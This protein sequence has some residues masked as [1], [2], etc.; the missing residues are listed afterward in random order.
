[1]AAAT[2]LAS[3]RLKILAADIGYSIS[4]REAT[5]A[6]SV[7]YLVGTFTPQIVGQLVGR[8]AVLAKR[9]IPFAATLTITGYERVAALF[10]S[11]VLATIG[12]IVLFGSVGMKLN[13]HG[14]SFLYLCLGV[15]LATSAGGL[16][17]WGDAAHRTLKTI[18]FIHIRRFGRSAL[19]SGLT[20]SATMAAYVVGASQFAPHVPLAQIAAASALVMLS[21]SIPISLAGWGI[22]ELSAVAA[23]GLLGIAPSA[24]LA[25]AVIIGASTIPIA[26]GLVLSDTLLP[27]KERPA[28]A[29]RPADFASDVPDYTTSLAWILPISVATLIFFQQFFPTNS[30]A[31]NLNLADPVAVIAGLMFVGVWISRRRWPPMRLNYFWPHAVAATAVIACSIVVGMTSIGWTSWAVLNKGVGWLVLLCYFSSGAL[32]VQYGGKDGFRALAETFVVSGCSTVL[33][34]V[35]GALATTGHLPARA[36]GFAQNAN[37]YA[38]Q[39]LMVAVVC[40]ALGRW[41]RLNGVAIALFGV[42]VSHSRAAEASAVVMAVAYATLLA[43]DRRPRL[44]LLA[45]SVAAGIASIAAYAF[46]TSASFQANLDRLNTSDSEHVRSVIEGWQM[47]LRHPVLGAGLGVFIH[48]HPGFDNGLGLII[49]STPVW[50]LAETGLIGTAIFVAPFVRMAATELRRW[51]LQDS[52]GRVLLF[53]LVGMGTMSTLHELLYQRTFWLLLGLCIA[54]EIAPAMVQAET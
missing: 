20:Q 25:V 40:I 36:A 31:I 7:G 24:S 26:A 33:L 28:R 41:Y 10:V 13:V 4:F 14:Y 38:F 29:P 2:G 11:V 44:A 43:F 12:A 48:R 18:Q 9:D 46:I 19:I 54:C 47:F 51:P 42:W 6:F 5:R 15:A 34:A 3:F 49:H 8:G 30:G 22:R 16:L 45:C 35:V 32:I 37:A 53:V 50:L 39:M 27:H 1:M 23:L 52:V 21:A 17:I